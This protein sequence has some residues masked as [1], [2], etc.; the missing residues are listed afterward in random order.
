M[1]GLLVLIATMAVAL[2]FSSAALANSVSCAHSATSCSNG[3]LGGP[4]G[5]P[6]TSGAGTLPF[7]GLDLGGIAVAGV[8]LLG[9]GLGLQRT[10]RRRQ[11]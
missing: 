9:C 3:Q 4:T 5:K 6:T 10:S 11:Q 1:K 2:A 7:T 8:V